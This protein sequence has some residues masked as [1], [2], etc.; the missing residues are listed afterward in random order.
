MKEPNRQEQGSDK[1][2]AN[3]QGQ[4]SDMKEAN[5][6]EQGSDKKEQE[7]YKKKP[8]LEPVPVVRKNV[9]FSQL[10]P[11]MIKK[12]TSVEE[13]LTISVGALVSTAVGAGESQAETPTKKQINA[14]ACISAVEQLIKLFEL[15]LK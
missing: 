6:Q 12:I 11:K 14:M 9:S 1:K 5:K 7:S 4:E 15:N 3:K 10:I 8:N 13:E 2:E